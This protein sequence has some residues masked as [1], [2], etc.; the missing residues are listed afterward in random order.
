MVPFLVS[1]PPAATIVLP[2]R[3]I[4]TTPFLTAAGDT[5]P[6]VYS[7]LPSSFAVFAYLSVLLQY[8]GNQIQF[9]LADR[10]AGDVSLLDA[11]CSQCQL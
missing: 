5:A 7:M 4:N 1:P 9:R 6:F 2:Q 3:L 8:T 11:C 10:P